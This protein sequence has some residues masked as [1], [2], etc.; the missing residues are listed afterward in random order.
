MKRVLGI[1]IP[2]GVESFS[3]FNA[4]QNIVNGGGFINTED[5]SREVKHEEHEDGEDKNKGK[6]GICLLKLK[7][8]LESFVV[9][10]ENVSIYDLI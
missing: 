6:V 7:T 5:D 8:S 10:D 2:N 3:F 1:K 9:W 4:C